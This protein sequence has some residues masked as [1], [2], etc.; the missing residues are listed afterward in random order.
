MESKWRRL[1]KVAHNAFFHSKATTS[2]VREKRSR[3]FSGRK[4]P[5]LLSNVA[6]RTSKRRKAEIA[7]CVVNRAAT[8][9]T[10]RAVCWTTYSVAASAEFVSGDFLEN[11][12]VVRVTSGIVCAKSYEYLYASWGTARKLE[13]K[14]PTTYAFVETPYIGEIFYSTIFVFLETCK[15]WFENCKLWKKCRKQKT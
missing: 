15:V 2:G 7:R 8:A 1:R 12:F 14:G 5:V 9:F 4:C 11:V 6:G 3:C 10:V 13:L